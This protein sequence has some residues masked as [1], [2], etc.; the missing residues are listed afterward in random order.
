MIIPKN[1][2]IVRTDRIGDVILSLP[3]AEIVK[4]YY[5]AC[6]ITFL[7]RSY[8]KSLVENN[9]F[10]DNVIILHEDKGKPAIKK[11]IIEISSHSFDSAII[12]SPTFITALIIFLS[13]IKV[14]IG[15][16]YRWYA[17]LFNKKVFVHRKYAQKHELEFNI[18]LLKNFGINESITTENVRFNLFPFKGSKHRIEKELEINNIFSGKPIVVVHPGSGGSA[19]DLPID[20]FRNLVELIDSK[21]DVNIIITGNQAEKNICEKL[22]SGNNVKN[23]AGRFDL[24]EL[25]A[26]IDKAD[27]F[28]SNS[29]GP[30]HI[31][32]ALNKHV[33]GFYPKILSCSPQRWGPYTNKKFIFMPE[34]NCTNCSREQCERLDCMSSVDINKVFKKVE[35]ICNSILKKGEFNV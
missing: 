20:K 34:I 6:K 31:A 21:L 35:E 18:D 12:V 13:R 15:T 7:I 8:T 22:V 14:R 28:I 33:I 27:L 30:I 25:I 4:K 10:I 1:L 11:N 17:F 26:L 16:G 29:T 3:L 19:V 32:A 9:S 24:S 2:L 23:F 5:P